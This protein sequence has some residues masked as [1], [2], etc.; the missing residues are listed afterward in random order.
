[1]IVATVDFSIAQKRKKPPDQG[2]LILNGSLA[3]SSGNRVVSQR[4][5]R[6]GVKTEAFAKRSFAR[7]NG[8]HGCCTGGSPMDG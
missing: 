3:L 2:G 8:Q 7:L 5:W 4:G 6:M 1:M